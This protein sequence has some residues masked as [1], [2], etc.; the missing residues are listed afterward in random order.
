MRGQIVTTASARQ[1]PG[2]AYARFSRIG[3]PGVRSSNRSGSAEKLPSA[4]GSSHQGSEPDYKD[5]DSEG[6]HGS[7]D[8]EEQ[9]TARERGNKPSHKTKHDSEYFDLDFDLEEDQDSSGDDQRAETHDY[10]RMPRR[11]NAS[12]S[13]NFNGGN[14]HEGEEG[15]D[16]EDE[17]ERLQRERRPSVGSRLPNDNISLAT[18]AAAAMVDRRPQSSDRAV[19][20]PWLREGVLRLAQA[21]L[22]RRRADKENSVYAELAERYD[23]LGGKVSALQQ[24]LDR[25]ARK[26]Q[27]KKSGSSGE[28]SAP[29]LRQP[30]LARARFLEK[31][32]NYVDILLPLRPDGTRRAARKSDVQALANRPDLQTGP[33]IDHFSVDMDPHTRKSSLWNQRAAAAFSKA[34]R[35]KFSGY[36]DAE[37]KDGFFTYL[38]TIQDNQR[39]AIDGVSDK[40]SLTARR[41]RRRNRQVLL[42]R[43]RLEV[44][45]SFS[46]LSYLVPIIDKLDAGHMSP[47]VSDN[48]SIRRGKRVSEKP[49]PRVAL[50][51][52]SEQLTSLLHDLDGL[53]VYMKRQRLGDR[54]DTGNPSRNRVDA[55]PPLVDATA[56]PAKGLPT[57][58][59]DI[60]WY[61]ST[62]QETEDL[63]PASK[64]VDLSLPPDLKRIANAHQYEP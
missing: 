1:P 19:I 40:D 46:R 23:D 58:C 57:N 31:I 62:G 42:Y 25:L 18:L 52:R 21:A 56:A 14:D 32:H 15:D 43:N 4:Y 63:D 51:W 48:E 49:Y 33:T 64:R 11:D 39:K 16:E 2:R 9:Y 8:R 3:P 17:I 38:R 35:K 54:R 10:F 27:H 59:Y 6:S 7:S 60:S 55:V 22:E 29:T 53:H 24:D 28:K 20:V 47:D 12:H 50:P 26:P 44:V 36:A 30:D 61:Q 5:S 13:S 45:T 37:V 34:F 41:I